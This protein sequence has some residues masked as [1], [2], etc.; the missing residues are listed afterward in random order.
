MFKSVFKSLTKNVNSILGTSAKIEYLRATSVRFCVVLYFLFFL[1]D[2]FLV[3]TPAAN[4][5]FS[6]PLTMLREG[7]L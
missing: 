2:F 1:N 4:L 7:M 5:A 3:W 6:G